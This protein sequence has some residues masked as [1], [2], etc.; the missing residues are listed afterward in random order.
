MSDCCTEER[1]DDRHDG[2]GGARNAET[3]APE[4]GARRAAPYWLGASLGL[5]AL[6]P[7]CP[8]CLVAYFSLFGLSGSAAAFV[9]PL[10]RPAALAIAALALAA[11]IVPL[12]ALVKR[13]VAAGSRPRSP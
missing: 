12:A 13:T 5:A 1:P 7:K 2:A 6:V 3:R 8:L 9:Y 11:L 10:L 4:R